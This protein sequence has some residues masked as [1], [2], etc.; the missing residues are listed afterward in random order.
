MVV[1]SK[2]PRAA[3]VITEPTREIAPAH[4]FF[5]EDRESTPE[6]T[7]IPMTRYVVPPPNFSVAEGTNPPRAPRLDTTRLP[8]N[9]LP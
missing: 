8:T 3:R 2:F 5:W 9:E 4:A 6:I 1:P 7:R